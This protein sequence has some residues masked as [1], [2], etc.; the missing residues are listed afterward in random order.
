MLASVMVNYAVMLLAQVWYWNEANLN[1][2]RI[3]KIE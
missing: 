2:A 1:Y 3:Y